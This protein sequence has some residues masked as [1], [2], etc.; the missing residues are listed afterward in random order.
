MADVS[1]Q[2]NP[3]VEAALHQL[4]VAVHSIVT[5]M[6][7]LTDSEL[8]ISPI[9]NKRSLRGL[10]VHLSMICMA[11]IRIAE[12][13]SEEAMRVFYKEYEPRTLQHAKE[14]TLAGLHQLESIYGAYSE[15]ELQ[16]M[17]TSYWGVSYSRYEWLMEMVGHLYHHRAQLHMMMA[18]HVREPKVALFE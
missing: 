18:E 9:A 8:D 15:A 4:K 10:I 1:P 12:G 3:Y 14:V 5:M 16:E 13:E 17:T 11:D 6:D 7:Q 2:V